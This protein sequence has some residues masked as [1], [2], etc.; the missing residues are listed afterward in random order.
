MSGRLLFACFWG[1]LAAWASFQ[2]ADA[3]DVQLVAPTE[4]LSAEEQQRRFHLPDGFSIQLVACEPEIAKPMNIRFDHRGRMFV[5]Q[6]VEYPFPAEGAAPRRD[7]IRRLENFGP[8]GRAGEVTT[9]VAGLNIPIGLLPVGDELMYYTIP[10]LKAAREPDE[11]GVFQHDE[12]LYETFGYRD[13]HGMC[14]SLTRGLDGW[15]YACHGFANTSHIRG[16]DEQE[17]VMHSGNT[18]RMRPDGSHCEQWTHGQVNPFG[19]AWDPWGNLYSADCHTK[20][21]YM[22]LRGAYYPSFGKPH[23][24]LGFGPEMIDH[25]HGS[26]GIAGVVYYAADQFPVRYRNTVLIGNP[27]TGRVNHD[28]LE[29]HGS[30]YRAIEQPDF[31]RCDDPWFRPVDL[32]LGPDGAL[33]IADFYNRIIGH[34]EVP[35]T[36]PGRDRHRGRI[37]RVVYTGE[38][39]EVPPFSVDFAAMSVEQLIE[40]LDDANLTV[41]TMATHE[42]ADRRDAEVVAHVRECATEGTTHQRVHGLW[43]LA[44]LGELEDELVTV[45]AADEE[46]VVRVHLTKALADR[47]WSASDDSIAVLVR[48]CLKDDNAFVRRAAADALGRHPDIENV[49]PLL[50]LWE[51][52]DPA[53]THLVHVARMALRDHL[54]VPDMYGHIGDIVVGNDDDAARIADVSLGVTTHEAAAYLLSHVITAAPPL[55]EVA[56]LLEH[57]TRYIDADQLPSIYAYA[58][59]H[60]SAPSGDQRQLLEALWRAYAARGSAPPEGVKRWAVELATELLSSAGEAELRAGI[61]FARA[62][63]ITECFAQLVR[64]AEGHEFTRL[65][66]AAIDACVECDADRSVTFLAGLLGDAEEPLDLRQKAADALGS[67]NTPDARAQLLAQ[68]KTAPERLAIEIAQALATSREGAELLLETVER[69]G[70]SARLLQEQVVLDRLRRAGPDR[71]GQRL[72]TLTA[73]LPPRDQRILDLIA[74]RQAGYAA[75]ET[76]PALGAQVFGKHCANCHRLAGEGNKIGPELDGIGQ[77]GLERLLEDLLSPSRNVDQAFRSTVVATVDGRVINGLALREEGQVLLLADQQGKEVRIAL[78]EIDERSV[79]PL[80]PM[81][82]NLVDMI[83]EADFYHL[84][85]YLL[86]QRVPPASQ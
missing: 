74:E 53:D 80:S 63:R 48:E 56:R 14:N 7:A 44:R 83:P 51:T 38:S 18:W 85:R 8:D 65:R 55:G 3:Q 24:G 5:T 25:L 70:A 61:D 77:R 1:C 37:W 4:A 28:R 16:D 17:I 36:H 11:Q 49:A 72:E 64:L 31:I 27:V 34:Y 22:L 54:L 79:S 2:R 43:V 76:D 50:D 67:V 73:G 29:Q 60:Q 69:G 19:L 75:A 82:T 86:E 10:H 58:E 6:S 35:L 59:I 9:V 40:R 66:P 57:A 39:S 42:L 30:T 13:T 41:R 12:V 68:L 47:Q 78:D 32:Q 20:P 84:L 33:Y 46:A 21:L 71:L 52:T 15:V 45:L 26:T 23:D 62:L 81:P